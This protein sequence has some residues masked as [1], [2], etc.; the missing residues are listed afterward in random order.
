MRSLGINKTTTNVFQVGEHQYTD[1]KYALEDAERKKASV[2]QK[3]PSEI[4]N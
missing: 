3:L 1:L 2:D 4:N